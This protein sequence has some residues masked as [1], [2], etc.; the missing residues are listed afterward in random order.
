MKYRYTLPLLQQTLRRLSKAKWFTKLD[1]R[2]ANTLVG[3]ADRKEW[4]TA[5]RSRFRHYEYMVMQFCLTN[6]HASFQHYI[7]DIL[8]E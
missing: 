5:F 2:G 1:L 8:R 6:A 3:M 7:N 4:K